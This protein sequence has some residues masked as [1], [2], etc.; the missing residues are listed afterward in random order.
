MQIS[1][2]VRLFHQYSWKNTYYVKRYRYLWAFYKGCQIHFK[3]ELVTNLSQAY[4]CPFYQI[5]DNN[6][7]VFPMSVDFQINFLIFI[8]LA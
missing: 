4:A 2:T 8:S 6:K 1:T 7:Y 5:N 3:N